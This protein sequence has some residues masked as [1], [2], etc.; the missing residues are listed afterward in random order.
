M[1][2]ILSGLSSASGR[3]L[4]GSVLIFIRLRG[5]RG[6]EAFLRRSESSNLQRLRRPNLHNPFNAHSFLPTLD[7]MAQNAKSG[8]GGAG[9]GGRKSKLAT[10]PKK[11]A[12]SIA[13]KKH[14]AVVSRSLQK[15]RPFLSQ[16]SKLSPGVTR[17]TGWRSF[18]LAAKGQARS[19]AAFLAPT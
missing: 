16:A 14:S 18:G 2:S 8:G 6:S 12:R 15:V 4:K 1:L 9:A 3:R 13:P 17:G 7:T 19:K 10:N 5:L 11:G